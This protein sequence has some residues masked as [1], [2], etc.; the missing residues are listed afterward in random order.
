MI[1]SSDMK[2]K[3]GRHRIKGMTF[4]MLVSIPTYYLYKFT[5]QLLAWWNDIPIEQVGARGPEAMESALVALFKLTVGAIFAV[6]LSTIFEKQV[7]EGGYGTYSRWGILF[8]AFLLG[9]CLLAQR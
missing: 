1:E 7:R 3:M 4:L 6:L 8:L 5:P 9:F 2:P